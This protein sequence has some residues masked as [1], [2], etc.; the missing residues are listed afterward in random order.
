MSSSGKGG[1]GSGRDRNGGRGPTHHGTGRDRRHASQDSRGGDGHHHHHDNRIHFLHSLS[2][3][4]VPSQLLKGIKVWTVAANGKT[5]PAF[6]ALSS[7]RFTATLRRD[8]PSFSSDHSTTGSPGSGSSFLF[9]G[10]R[11]QDDTRSIDIGEMDRVQRGQSTQ[12]FERARKRG[13]FAKTASERS[14][15][16]TF[17]PPTAVKVSPKP[18]RPKHH[19]QQPLDPILSFSIIFRGAHTLDLMAVT[20][21]DREEICDTLDQL[22]KAY[23]QG[24]V[25]VST[26]VLLLRYIWLYVVD[27]KNSKT[28]YC[29]VEQV[30]KVLTAINFSMKQKDVVSAY[31]QFGRVI[32]LDR[33][34]RRRGLT[35][36]QAATFLHKIKRDSWFVKPVNVLWNELF[37]E[38]MNNQ[39]MRTTVSEKTFLEKFLH[40]KQGQKNATIVDV[41]KIFRRLHDMEFAHTSTEPKDLSRINKEQFEAYL[42][43]SENDAFSPEKENLILQDMNRP[44][45]EYF[46]NSSHN[47]YLTGDQY[48]SPSSVEMYSNA[49]YRGARC[50]E[51]DIWDGGKTSD[52]TPIAVV[53]HGHTLTTKILFEDIIKTI[54]VFLNFHPDSWPIVLS[55]ENH[56]SIPYQQVMAE[57]LVR[58][59]G[60][61]LYVPTEASLFGPLPSPARL[62]GMVV[63]KGRRPDGT[64]A[65]QYDTDDESDDEGMSN[66]NLPMGVELEEMRAAREKVVS[67]GVAP[68]LASLTLFHGHKL[69]TFDESI[70]TPTYYMHSFS[71]S[72]VRS[73]CRQKQAQRWIA[74]NQSHMSRTYPAGSRVDSSNYN[75]LLAWSTG[76]QMAALNFQ[77]QDAF[78][79]LNDGR[80]RENG[81]CGYVLKPSSLMIKD[82]VGSAS[83]PA[84]LSI[85]VLSGSCLPKPKGQIQG[86]CIDPY[87]KV[88]VYDVKNEERET[89]T[90]YATN[91]V[92]SNGFFPIWSQEKFRFRI[93][94]WDVAMLQL[95]VVDKSKEEFIASSSIPISCL[96]R[97]IRCVK[98]YDAT[99]TRSGAF[100]FASLLLDIQIGQM[101]AEI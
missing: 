94:N 85:R 20:P 38:L 100:D 47:T 18:S 64:E 46:I 69:N 62:R 97:G 59:L 76:C 21:E 36:G 91:M 43:A 66:Q 23:Q 33:L 34:K 58:I 11:S 35:F 6:L 41:R 31:D 16:Q 78:L 26:D 65:D 96:R 49:L 63:I 89:V 77:T 5:R 3:V 75:P 9:F 39:K 93:D 44:L 101:V 19:Q 48:K 22:L 67:Y 82:D 90:H 95:T 8:G 57:Q 88:S 79:R 61:S 92:A 27:E 12:Q 53:W 68:E 15:E 73:R 17:I 74:Y 42:L 4:R 81:N 87:V 29:T 83:A 37:G 70:R 55:F 28:V 84:R 40:G 7:D 50:L 25:R 60:D 14:I 13:G 24:K 30:G 54:K 45:S 10:R 51:L 80:F 56:C 86:D 52:G 32:G 99:N 71:E 2:T 1:R 72:K 98:L